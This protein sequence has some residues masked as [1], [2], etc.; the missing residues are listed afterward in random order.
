METRSIEEHLCAQCHNRRTSPDP[1]STHGLEPHAPE[2][3]LLVGEAGWFP[4]G[5]PVDQGEIFGTHGSEANPGLCATCHV[6]AF[7]VTD[8]A[9]GNFVFHATGHLFNAI[10]VPGRRRA[11]HDR[12]LRLSTT[13]RSFEGCTASGCH[14]SQ[15]AARSAFA[16]ATN[17]IEALVTTV[18]AL[19]DQVPASEFAVDGVETTAEGARFNAELG[20]LPGSPVHNPF[21]MEALLT[22][23]IKQVQQDYG[24]KASPALSLQNVLGTR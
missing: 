17:R 21:F 3:A 19:L 5:L 6:N 7:D 1:T 11:S 14:G 22:A 23:T 16:V 20:G 13:P 9:T 8:P 12:G 10:P 15:D 4:P 2:G 18:N 24:V